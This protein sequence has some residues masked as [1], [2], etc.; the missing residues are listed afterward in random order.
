MDYRREYDRFVS[1]Y[2][3]AEGLRITTGVTLPA[4]V[5]YFLGELEIG[6]VMSLGAMCVS[7]SD[8]PGPIQLRRNGMLVCTGVVTLMAFVAGLMSGSPWLMGGMI[9]LSCFFFSMLGVYG[10]RANAIGVAAL[11]ILVLG[12]FRLHGDHAGWKNAL[13]VGL[14]GAWYMLMSLA[15]Y[16]FR[17]FRLI[18]QALGESITAVGDYLRAR[19]LFYFSASDHII[20]YQDVIERQAEVQK[21]QLLV[22]ELMYRSRHIT[23]ESS[24]TSRT[25][26]MMFTDTIDLF[27]RATTSFY[28]YEI[29]H[30]R[31]GQS[32]ILE[33]FGKCVAALGEALDEV[34]VAVQA[35]REARQSPELRKVYARLVEK[36]DRFVI[37][38]RSQENL[39]PLI[40]LR[41]ILQAIDDVLSRV[42]SL[43]LYSAYDPERVSKFTPLENYG[44]FIEKTDLRPVL[45]LDNLTVKSSVFR[46]SLRLSLATITGYTISHLFTFGHSYWILLTIIV[47]L[48]PAYSLTR[49]RNLERVIGT[50]AGALIGI[51]LIYLVADRGA[52]FTIMLI[53]MAASYSFMRTRYLVSVLFMTPYVLIL[54]YLLGSSEFKLVL[55][56][57]LVD[58]LIGSAIAFL[59][60]VML[61]PSWEK[62]QLPHY[63]QET[64]KGSI[65]YFTK[66]A[67]LLLPGKEGTKYKL[68]RKQA[69]VSLG[70]LSEA[71][72]RMLHEPKRKQTSGPL[73]HQLVVLLHNLHSHIASLAHF[74]VALDEKYKTTEFNGP[75]TYSLDQLREAVAG[76]SGIDFV[77]TAEGRPHKLFASVEQ[78]LEARWVELQQGNLETETKRRLSQLKPIADQFMFI[79]NI[80]GD[81]NKICAKLREQQ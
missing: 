53:L 4:I 32:G 42:E 27:E 76:L 2:Y 38:H 48:K 10:A 74:A 81:I 41:K 51:L 75:V 30:R 79:S 60:S 1:S 19:S 58:T 47:I 45:L 24:T 67:D 29:L 20:I 46:H 63:L 77:P 50:V 59:A 66:V 70:N 35:G 13:L 28:S 62:L 9:A 39:E 36:F 69:F 73:I 12:I 16:S 61:L 65:A 8:I 64:I 14:G 11:L 78:L 7:A 37:D 5:F 26:L 80:A 56:D 6:M 71:F 23:K 17:P 33:D 31:F 54:F 3:F 15:V 55:Q 43:Q 44:S 52:L 18:Q 25:L 57:R 72:T 40:S 21:K 34:G 22:R 49:T 68:E